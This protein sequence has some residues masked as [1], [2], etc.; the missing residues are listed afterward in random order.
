MKL[1]PGCGG[2]PSILCP[3]PGY[4]AAVN[5]ARGQEGGLPGMSNLDN[6]WGKRKNNDA[7]ASIG[8]SYRDNNIAHIAITFKSF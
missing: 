1:V 3:H 8:L 5:P 6:S 2:R 4:G 7:V